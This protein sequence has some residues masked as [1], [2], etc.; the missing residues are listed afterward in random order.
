MVRC[1]RP[2]RVDDCKIESDHFRATLSGRVANPMKALSASEAVWPAVERTVDHL[3]KP[4]RWWTFFKVSALAV[5]TE[6]TLVNFRF[7]LSNVD[8]QDSDSLKHVQSFVKPESLPVTILASLTVLVV[9]LYLFV[10]LMQLRFAFFYC[11]LERSTGIRCAWRRCGPPAERF[12]FASLMV[13]LGLLCMVI[14]FIVAVAVVVFVVFT[15]R[16]PD[17]KLDP[18]VFLILFF[19][20]VGFAALVLG[21]AVVAD[22]VMHDFIL[23]HMA[24]EDLSFREA[25]TKV[26][27]Q[28]RSHK[29]TFFSYIILRLLLPFLAAVA[30]ILVNVLLLPVL[31]G[32]A[33]M[34]LAG[35]SKLLDDSTA[36]GVYLEVALKVLSIALGIA[37]GATVAVSLGGPLGVFIRNYA[38]VFYAGHYRTLRDTL[39]PSQPQV[40]ADGSSQVF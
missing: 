26:K 35:Y 20:C 38:L 4:F 23:P 2:I 13:W 3:F 7:S 17:G 8:L 37:M 12:S 40:T 10:L 34:S 27:T 18:G 39:Q 25:W 21:S 22:V 5:I 16:T 32:I 33:G 14:L 1:P 24:L 36:L 15:A 11:V 9:A 6:G 30:L 28:L 31:F 29:E 19:P